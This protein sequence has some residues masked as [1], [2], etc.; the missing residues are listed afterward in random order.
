MDVNF[1][2]I[3]GG[4]IEVKCAKK[5]CKFKSKTEKINSII[6]QERK[7]GLKDF[8]KFNLRMEN[9]KKSATFFKYPK[10]RKK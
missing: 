1:N 9:S 6:K 3:N 4:S 2:E 5:N 10:K 8:E 7:I